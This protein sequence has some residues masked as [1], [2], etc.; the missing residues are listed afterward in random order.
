MLF[1]PKNSYVSRALARQRAF[2][3]EG[4]RY[5]LTLVTFS[6]DK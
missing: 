4:E 6:D 3:F 5:T 1:P 2:D